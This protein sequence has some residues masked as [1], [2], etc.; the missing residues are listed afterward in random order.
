MSTFKQKSFGS[1]ILYIVDKKIKTTIRIV[2]NKTG[3]SY[4]AIHGWINY[5]KVPTMYQYI[6]IL[7]YFD[8]KTDLTRQHLNREMIKLIG[9]EIKNR[10]K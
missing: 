7:D 2:S 9:A 10:K 8:E 1:F 3:V 5:D 6:K 4:H